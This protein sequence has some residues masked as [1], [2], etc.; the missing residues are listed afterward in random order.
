[1]TLENVPP[2]TGFPTREHLESLVKIIDSVKA[3][4]RAYLVV[5][6]QTY[7]YLKFKPTLYEYDWNGIKDKPFRIQEFYGWGGMPVYR[8]PFL[9]TNITPESDWPIAEPEKPSTFLT[10]DLPER[11]PPELLN[12]DK[13][14]VVI[15]GVVVLLILLLGVAV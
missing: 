12:D 6:P 5:D 9:S 13:T 2:N 11:L 4:P 1:M 7:D 15:L 10:A 3:P 8:T 14:T